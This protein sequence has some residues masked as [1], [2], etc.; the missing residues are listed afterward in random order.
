MFHIVFLCFIVIFNVILIFMSSI[1]S[2]LHATS[3]FNSDF[4]V[5]ID[6]YFIL[7]IF[8]FNVFVKEI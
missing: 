7:V 1:V 5:I 4:R 2:F 3:V 6:K 8:E